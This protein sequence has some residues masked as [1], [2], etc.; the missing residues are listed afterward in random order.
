MAFIGQSFLPGGKMKKKNLYVRKSYEPNRLSK[1]YLTDAYKKVT[2]RQYKQI[3]T[4]EKPIA[5]SEEN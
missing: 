4:N 3:E 1:N 2:R 5:T